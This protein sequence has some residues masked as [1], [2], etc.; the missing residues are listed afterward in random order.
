MK[1][2]M[3]PVL[4]AL[5]L[6]VSSANAVDVSTQPSGVKDLSSVLQNRADEAKHSRCMSQCAGNKDFGRCLQVCKNS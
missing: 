3:I 1:K 4:F 5:L 6:G 2:V